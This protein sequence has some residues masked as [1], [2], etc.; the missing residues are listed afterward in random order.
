MPQ[1]RKAK[2]TKALE[3]NPGKGRLDVVKPPPGVPEKPPW[4]QGEASAEWDR[5]IP[6]LDAMGVLSRLDRSAVSDYCTVWGRL[7]WCEQRIQSTDLL[8]KGQ[9]GE[10]VRNPLLSEANQLRQRF[11]RY[12]DLLGLAPAPRGRLDVPDRGADDDPHGLLD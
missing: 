6:I 4:L 5:V 9:K 11:G 7:V 12:C 10:L 8:L 3:N 2:Q 1:L